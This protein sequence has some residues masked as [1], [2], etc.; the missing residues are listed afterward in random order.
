MRAIFFLVSVLLVATPGFAQIGSLSTSA[1][2]SHLFVNGGG[3]K[4]VYFARN[5]FYLDGEFDW[6]AARG[7]VP[8]LLGAGMNFAG[9]VRTQD[10][11]GFG[12][13]NYVFEVGRESDVI[14]MALEARAAVPISPPEWRGWYLMPKLG[15]GLLID[16][17]SIETP[18]RLME[19]TAA[20]FE[21]RPAIQAGY[22]W[23]R[24]SLGAECAY[25]AASGNF[26]TFGNS[27]QQLQAGVFFRLRV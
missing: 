1:G 27:A 7:P 23:G 9:Y 26:G 13:G 5:G 8:L 16:S 17:Y 3:G 14:L 11:A 10:I 4:G 18:T 20:A 24:W 21:V 22:S 25:M 12:G 6:Q 15:A 2:W 19:H